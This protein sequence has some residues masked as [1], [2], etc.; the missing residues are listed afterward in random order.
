MSVT[1]TAR[2]TCQPEGVAADVPAAPAIL[3]NNLNASRILHCLVYPQ[4]DLVT[5]SAPT[6]E[7]P[8]LIDAV[9]FLASV[10]IAR[11]YPAD[12]LYLADRLSQLEVLADFAI[13]HGCFI[14]WHY[15][16]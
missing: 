16:V 14:T 12:S 13:L 6:R 5:G 15:D 10:I 2:T 11:F 8:A 7:R 4:I 1:F 3:T 9:D